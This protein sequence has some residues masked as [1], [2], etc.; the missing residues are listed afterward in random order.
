VPI[1]NV[2]S[3]RADRTELAVDV[4]SPIKSASSLSMPGPKCDLRWM[5]M[6]AS[7]ID[8]PPVQV[9]WQRGRFR[10]VR[11]ANSTMKVEHQS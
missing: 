3:V 9:L 10:D 5:I 11:L 4:K 2:D 7:I 8:P 1:V 6:P